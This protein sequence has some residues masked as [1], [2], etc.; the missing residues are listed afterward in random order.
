M[1]RR[2]RLIILH[3]A[4]LCVKMIDANEHANDGELNF[5]YNLSKKR[6]YST[7]KPLL[8]TQPHLRQITLQL[9]F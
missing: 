3:R 4:L 2:T 6:A 7:L 8:S 1:P 5:V 9:P